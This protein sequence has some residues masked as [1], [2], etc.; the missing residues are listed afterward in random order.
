MTRVVTFAG[1]CPQILAETGRFGL[2][3]CPQGSCALVLPPCGR[4]ALP[5]AVCEIDA[6]RMVSVCDARPAIGRA[7]FLV[8]ACAGLVLA[9]CAPP[10]DAVAGQGRTFTS[11]VG[12]VLVVRA[13]AVP[14]RP[15]LPGH[16]GVDLV[17]GPAGEIYAPAAG[18]ISYTGFVVN[19]PVI[20]VTHAPGVVSSFEP[21]LGSVDLGASVERGQVLGTIDGAVPHC[22]QACVHWGV[23]IDG[24]YVD[25]LDYLSG[26]GQVR[27][28][29]LDSGEGT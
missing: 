7:W 29:P 13:A 26:F 27:L 12:D 4:L 23:R 2:P 1:R 10:A 22:Q 6:L 19:R 14:E 15:W 25:P 5:V 17:V 8:L 9:L 20:S 11:P 21:V 18:T 24:Q 16:R 3:R 28:L